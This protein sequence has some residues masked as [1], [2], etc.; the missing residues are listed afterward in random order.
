[1]RLSD[2]SKQAETCISKNPYIFVYGF[3][4]SRAG[5]EPATA[6]SESAV[7]SVRL[8]RHNIIYYSIIYLICQEN[9][10]ILYKIKKN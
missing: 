1:M 6:E 2:N 4:A 10:S 7:L 5:I 8:P 9:L 3:L